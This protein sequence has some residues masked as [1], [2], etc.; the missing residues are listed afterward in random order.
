MSPSLEVYQ[1]L[2][3]MHIYLHEKKPGG[4]C[5]VNG[6]VRIVRNEVVAVADNASAANIH[7]IPIG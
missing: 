6:Y 3:Q 1:D 2:R 4:I 7:R 5:E